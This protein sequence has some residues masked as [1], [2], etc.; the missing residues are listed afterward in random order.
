MP[1]ENLF[2]KI[3]RFIKETFKLEGTDVDISDEDRYKNTVK[4]R[5][6]KPD[7]I[8]HGNRVLVQ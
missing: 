7:D 1:P 8:V 5:H 2:R 4:K 3:E 6:S